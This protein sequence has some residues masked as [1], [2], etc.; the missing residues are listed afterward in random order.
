MGSH[1][2]DLHQLYGH[3][4]AAINGGVEPRLRRDGLLKTGADNLLPTGQ[5]SSFTPEY[6]C[7]LAAD[8]RANVNPYMIVQYTIFLRSHNRIASALKRLHETWTD[9]ELFHAAKQINR[10]VY[11]KI[12]Y[13]EWLPWVVG[14]TRALQIRNPG[15]DE[16][17]DGRGQ[18]RVLGVSNEFATAA[19]RFYNTMMPG[20][21][22]DQTVPTGGGDQKKVFEL[23]NTFYQTRSSVLAS[24]QEQLIKIVA[25]ALKQTAMAMD[26]SYVDDVSISRKYVGGVA[27]K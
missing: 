3:P 1:L 18:A 22:Y 23:R 6:T 11:Q 17:D 14:Q 8:S 2:L 24:D 5:C 9:D 16:A 21:L 19:I 4:S 15:H 13:E 20:D 27:R 25:S 7:R 12:S 26:A 10:A